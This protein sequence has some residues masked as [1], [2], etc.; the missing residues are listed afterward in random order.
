MTGKMHKENC[1][2]LKTLLEDIFSEK[3]IEIKIDII[4][5]HSKGMWF[6]RMRIKVPEKYKHLL[7]HI[8]STSYSVCALTGEYLDPKKIKRG[9]LYLG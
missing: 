1:R 7:D 5:K 8:Y 3:R 6:W 4:D 2:R 9:F